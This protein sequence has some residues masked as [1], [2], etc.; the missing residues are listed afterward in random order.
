ME[1]I[2]PNLSGVN[3]TMLLTFYARAEYSKSKNSKFYDAKAVELVD[4]I[5]YDFTKASKDTLM[6]GGTIA[7][8]LVFDELVKDFITKN[9]NAT[10]VNIACGLDTRVYRMDN[11]KITWYN[12]D[13]PDTIR[14]RNQIF[15]ESG[16][17]IT[18]GKSAMDETWADDIKVRNKMLFIIEGL[19]MYLTPKEVEKMLS[20]IHDNFDNAYVL[21]ETTS[22]MWID[23]QSL[24]KSVQDT[25]SRFI[26][27]ADTFEDIQH[28]AKGFKRVKDDN[29][30]RGM[31]EIKPILKPFKNLSVVKKITEK[32]LIF[33]KD[34]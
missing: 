6:S 30:I 18:I 31:V 34:I 28:L 5:D 2:K 9:P 24:E 25:G 16:R 12:L 27:G 32:I 13:L 17:I 26:F 29:I 23:R 14:V 20:I 8:T 22:K 10:I 15:N 19:T 4:K 21:M 33:E 7:R 3:E 11:K 1:K